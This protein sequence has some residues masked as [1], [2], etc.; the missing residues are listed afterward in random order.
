MP[1]S[2]EYFPSSKKVCLCKHESCVLWWYLW[3]CQLTKQKGLVPPPPQEASGVHTFW[4]EHEGTYGGVPTLCRFPNKGSFG[5]Q[6]GSWK[7]PRHI[8]YIIVCHVLWMTQFSDKFESSCCISIRRTKVESSLS[9]SLHPAYGR[10][11]LDLKSSIMEC[12][13]I[14]EMWPIVTT[15]FKITKIEVLKHGFNGHVVRE[16]IMLIGLYGD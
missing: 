9:I 5:G 16:C 2:R 6:D 1:P 11:G 15:G 10:E 4:R 7:P 12:S 8:V 13:S 3:P 14:R